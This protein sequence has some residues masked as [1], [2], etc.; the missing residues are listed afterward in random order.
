MQWKLIPIKKRRT[1]FLDNSPDMVMLACCILLY[2][3]I[4]ASNGVYI[5]FK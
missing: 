2:P 5:L 1:K 4:S 3:D